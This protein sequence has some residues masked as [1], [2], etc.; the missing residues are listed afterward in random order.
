MSF[1]LEV[2]FC[3]TGDCDSTLKWEERSIVI[4]IPI[5]MNEIFG[6]NYLAAFM[7]KRE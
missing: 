6:M 5:G 2:T 1:T 3:Q 7:G 4:L